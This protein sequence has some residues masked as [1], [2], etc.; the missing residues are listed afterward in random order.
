MTALPKL[1]VFGVALLVAITVPS[2]NDH[3]LNP[4]PMRDNPPSRYDW[5]KR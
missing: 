5:G 2:S 1:V 4:Q 3:D